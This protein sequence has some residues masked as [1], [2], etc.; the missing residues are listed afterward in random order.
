MPGSTLRDRRRTAGVF[1]ALMIV[2]I[3]AFRQPSGVAAPQS[4]R[5]N[6]ALKVL[7]KL[8]EPSSKVKQ[9]GSIVA[10]DPKGR[11]LYYVWRAF[12]GT[13]SVI[14]YDLNPA[15][16]KKIRESVVA[17]L[18]ATFSDNYVAFDPPRRHP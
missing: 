7:G 3:L 11:R 1:F 18:P 2:T 15:I 4:I 8:P 12:S 10:I 9:N 5:S 13:V 6:G 17:G 14:E 16:P